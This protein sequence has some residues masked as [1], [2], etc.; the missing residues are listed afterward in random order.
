MIRGGS[1][2]CINAS[3]RA[4]PVNQFLFSPVQKAL[5]LVIEVCLE[6]PCL[7]VFRSA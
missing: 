7:L 1:V 4:G 2:R 6:R 3:V 5:T